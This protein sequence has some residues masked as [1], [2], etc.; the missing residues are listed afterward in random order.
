VFCC[1]YVSGRVYLRGPVDF[2]WIRLN[3]YRR[4][5]FPK[6]NHK[7]IPLLMKQ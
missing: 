6:A 5:P 3:E 4:Y 2:R 7:F 1:N